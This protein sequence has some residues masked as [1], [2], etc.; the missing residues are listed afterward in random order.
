MVEGV[1]VAL[2][3]SVANEG[4]DQKQQ[5]AFGLVEV[6]YQSVDN[7]I[8][9]AGGY[10][11]LGGTVETVSVVILHPLEDVA[12]GVDIAK[13]MGVKFV[14]VPLADMHVVEMG[15]CIELYTKPI[16]ALEGAHGGGAHGN[17]R[18]TLMSD[19]AT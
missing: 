7:S 8:L 1:A 16:E 3:P 18:T 19:D 6:G 15:V 14:W 2:V 9:V 5:C 10:H 17:E 11:E 13:V 4:G 12:V